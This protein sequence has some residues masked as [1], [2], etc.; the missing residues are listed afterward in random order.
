VIVPKANVVMVT[1]T[2]SALEKL[3]SWIDAE[4]LAAMGTIA[5]DSPA[6]PEGTRPPSVGAVASR[7]CIHFYLLAFARTHR[8]RMF[9]TQQPGSSTKHYPEAAVWLSQQGH[10][11]LVLEYRRINELISIAQDAVAQGWVEPR[12]DRTLT[13][14]AQKRLEIRF[15]L[16]SPLPGADRTRAT[17]KAARRKR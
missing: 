5:P 1:D 4:I 14:S 9:G 17:K 13:P 7:E 11:A 8:I 16:V 2:D 10:E 12:P 3:G 15:G 6:Q